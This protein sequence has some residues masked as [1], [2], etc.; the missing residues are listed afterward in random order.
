MKKLVLKTVGITLACIISACAVL[1]GIFA[2]FSPKTIAEVADKMGN[3][4]VS[5]FYYGKSYEKSGD[6]ED[7]YTVI[8]KADSENDR[9]TAEKYCDIMFNP[10]KS[11]ELA[12]FASKKDGEYPSSAVKTYEYL[13]G[14]YSVA[15]ASQNT[16]EKTEKLVS[17]CFN[18]IEEK[19]Y[20]E[21]NPLTVA[22]VVCGNKM[23]KQNLQ[24]LSAETDKRLNNGVLDK[25]SAEEKSRCFSDRN[26]LYQIINNG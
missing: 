20:T 26:R 4:S 2:L 7:L 9:A 13:Y 1:F 17:V 14:K 24:Y 8:V 23:S 22:I 16:L 21:D 5:V 6:I 19:G 11:G 10:S 3:Y 25:L 15:L 12:L 18:Y